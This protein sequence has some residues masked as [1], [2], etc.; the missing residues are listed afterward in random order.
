MPLDLRS[1]ASAY[2]SLQAK[3]DLNPESDFAQVQISTDGIS[4]EPICGKYTVRGGN[5]QDLDNPVYSGTQKNW[6]AEWID[7]KNM[8]AEVFIFKYL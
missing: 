5:F 7:L 4:Y 6:I 8:W 2:L 1:A 3:W